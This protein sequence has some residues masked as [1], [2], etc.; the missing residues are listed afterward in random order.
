MTDG[1]W[2]ERER[3]PLG[4]LGQEG[5]A[6]KTVS[7]ALQSLWR[8][9]PILSPG[10]QGPASLILLGMAHPRSTRVIEE[11]SGRPYS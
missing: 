3:G 5:T 9:P 11:T 1:G 7:S 6:G 4:A 10:C 2:G 8:C